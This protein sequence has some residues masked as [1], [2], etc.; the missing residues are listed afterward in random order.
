MAESVAEAELEVDAGTGAVVPGSSGLAAVGCDLGMA[1]GLLGVEMISL[2]IIPA[3][4]PP[5]HPLVVAVSVV[6]W[7]DG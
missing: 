3:N 2:A 5:P 6:C 1:E 4:R 7:H